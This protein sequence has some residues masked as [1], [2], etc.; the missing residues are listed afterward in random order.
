MRPFN[1]VDR[2]DWLLTNKIQT[3]SNQRKSATILTEFRRSTT[4]KLV[5]VSAG[6]SSI[7]GHD[8]KF[9]ERFHLSTKT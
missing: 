3:A 1:H 6:F 9:S 8:S 4:S 5:D 7:V 2:S